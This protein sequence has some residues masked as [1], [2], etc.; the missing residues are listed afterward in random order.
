MTLG[1]PRY[2][3]LLASLVP[4]AAIS[5]FW[6]WRRYVAVNKLIPGVAE[7]RRLLLAR[8]LRVL[9]LVLGMA[10]MV[11]ALSQPR[12][13]YHWEELERKGLEILLLLDVSTSMSAQ[14]IAP[15][16]LERARREIRDLLPLLKGDRIGLVVF[17]GAAYLRMPL[18]TDHSLL[19]AVL[20]QLSGET[21]KTAGTSLGNAM[22]MGLDTLQAPGPADRAMVIF[23]DG[24]DPEPQEALSAASRASR[25]G[26]R[27][28]TVGVGT[29]EGAAIPLP[30]GTLKKDSAGAIV[31][32]R[33]DAQLLQE[34]AREGHGAY[35]PSVP[36]G[37]DMAM[38]V[39]DE[40]RAKLQRGTLGKRRERVWDERFQWPLALGLLLM[41]LATWGLRH[42]KPRAMALRVVVLALSG[43]LASIA[44]SMAGTAGLPLQLGQAPSQLEPTT[45]TGWRAHDSVFEAGRTLFDAGRFSEAEFVWAAKARGGDP[46]Q[47]LALYDMGHAAYQARRLTDAL[48]HFQAAC[49]LKEGFYEACE[50]AY[51]VAQELAA[52]TREALHGSSGAGPGGDEEEQSQ[53]SATGTSPRDGSGSG[54][55]A[56]AASGADT[57]APTPA[58]SPEKVRPT[59]GLPSVFA[60]GS[61]ESG[62]HGDDGVPESAG[63]GISRQQAAMLLNSVPEGTPVI[64]LEPVGETP[65]AQ[66]W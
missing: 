41:M 20:P 9:L 36:S 48:A 65:A 21:L 54:N 44:S 27:L 13:G 51:A 23:T 16:R 33:L 46:Y 8:L 37:N 14:D 66:D 49:D 38:L 2:L 28:Y 22:E 25:A 50:D 34:I 60:E 63:F 10:C 32:S 47:A 42:G 58:S 29:A 57:E 18:T 59:I 62:R 19:E 39:R 43:L 52:R 6:C 31:H 5:F 11:F 64:E 15:D 4:L 53:G 35:V 1:A 55:S 12:S 3:L 45:F 61:A 40:I 26:I 24:E 17:A 56:A 7:L 30:D